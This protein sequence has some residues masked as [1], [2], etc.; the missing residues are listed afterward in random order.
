MDVDF[1]IVSNQQPRLLATD[2]GKPASA[3]FESKIYLKLF[4]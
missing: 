1:S 2:K 4:D 3:G